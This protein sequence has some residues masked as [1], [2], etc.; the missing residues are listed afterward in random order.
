M[1]VISL[2]IQTQQ[3]LICL[4]LRGTERWHMWERSRRILIIQTDLMSVFRFC[5]ERVWLDAVTGRLNGTVVIFLYQRQIK[6]SR[7]KEPVTVGLDTTKYP[8]VCTVY[9]TDSLS[10]TT[11]R[12]DCYSLKCS[13]RVGVYLDWS[14][15]TLSFYNISDTHTHTH[16]FP[17]P[18][19]AGF[20]V[21]CDSSVSV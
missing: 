7:R 8:G 17:E 18:L 13:D 9:W 6:E 14:A 3:T 15:G 12:A 2:W 5:V 11:V 19:C 1:H 4:C 16:T 10:N 20:G 21:D